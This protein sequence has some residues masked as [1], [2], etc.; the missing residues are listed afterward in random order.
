MSVAETGRSRWALSQTEVIYYSA[1]MLIA[2]IAPFSGFI[3]QVDFGGRP[4]DVLSLLWPLAGLALGAVY[5][6]L[7]R[8]P[9][10]A[11]EISDQFFDR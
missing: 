9:T 4:I 1:V 2:I 8:R 10:A 5:L 7:R 6:G 11:D 3:F